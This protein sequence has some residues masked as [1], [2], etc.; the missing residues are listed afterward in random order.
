MATTLP[1][2]RTPTP[3]GYTAESAADGDGIDSHDLSA[4]ALLKLGSNALVRGRPAALLTFMAAVNAA[5]LEPKCVIDCG[6]QALVVGS[7]ARTLLLQN[8]ERLSTSEQYGLVRCLSDMRAAGTQVV[9]MTS[10]PLYSW[11]QSQ[12]FSS[13]LYYYLNTLYFELD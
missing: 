10:V 5:V 3:H 9:A 2:S 13:D 8:V 1:R 11:V 7:R 6:R 4:L 12:R